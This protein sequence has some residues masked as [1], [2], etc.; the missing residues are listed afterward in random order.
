VKQELQD[1]AAEP[2]Q[3]PFGVPGAVKL[4]RALG[5]TVGGVC[6]VFLATLASVA[7]H[8][9]HPLL[10]RVVAQKVAA[11]VAKKFK[12]SVQLDGLQRFGLE[13]VE[14]RRLR[15]RD[16][17]GKTV[18]DL[19]GVSLHPPAWSAVVAG[20]QQR[21][22][23]L[24]ALRVSRAEIVLSK[25]RG[26]LTLSEALQRRKPSIPKAK[27]IAAAKRPLGLRIASLRVEALRVR[28]EGPDFAPKLDARLRKIALSLKHDGRATAVRLQGL[29]LE[30]DVALGGK[31]RAQ[32][33][34]TIDAEPSRSKWLVTTRAQGQFE[35]VG[36]AHE[37]S[38]D[39]KQIRASLA[40]PGVP[41]A[42]LKQW[43][44]DMPAKG[45]LGLEAR[46]SGR[47]PL[48]HLK[49]RL[50]PV[51]GNGHSAGEVAIDLAANV[52][53]INQLAIRLRSRAFDLSRMSVRAPPSRLDATVRSRLSWTKGGA[54]HLAGH[55]ESRNSSL[56]GRA[57]PRLAGRFEASRQRLVAWLHAAELGAEGSVWA[58]V[59]D[60]EKPA[61]K[62]RVDFAAALV[63]PALQRLSR[64]RAWIPALKSRRLRGKAALELSGSLR[65]AQLSAYG[66]ATLQRFAYAPAKASA[67]GFQ[68]TARL[69]GPLTAL[70]IQARGAAHAVRL[71]QRELDTL[72]FS[73]SG[74]LKR[75]RL[76]TQAEAEDGSSLWLA[77]WLDH[78]ARDV[79]D[80]RVKWSQGLD[81]VAGSVARIVPASRRVEDLNLR[82]FG[83]TLKG[84][85][86][87]DQGVPHGELIA[88]GISLRS[89]GRSWLGRPLMRGRFGARLVLPTTPDTRRPARLRIELE[90]VA[91]VHPQWA[92]ASGSVA[93]TFDGKRLVPTGNLNFGAGNCKEAMGNVVLAGQKIRLGGPLLRR[94]SWQRVAG[95]VVLRTQI[96]QPECLL[97]P[98]RKLMG[99]KVPQL[100]G[101]TAIQLRLSR[102]TNKG[103]PTLSLK[104]RTLRMRAHL[105]A[106]KPGA[107]SWRSEK[108]DLL[109]DASV[110][111]TGEL[112]VHA[113]VLPTQKRIAFEKLHAE[114][115]VAH[116]ELATQFEPKEVWQRPAALL[117]RLASGRQARRQPIHARLQLP[118]QG[119]EQ[120]SM[121]PSPLPKHFKDWA[122]RI[123]GTL[124]FDGSLARPSIAA[125]LRLLRIRS[126][127]ESQSAGGIDSDL[128]L[129]Y[130]D[131]HWYGHAQF[132]RRGKALARIEGRF[133][134]D[135]SSR[136]DGN[137]GP[138]GPGNVHL[139][140]S[141]ARV[142]T[143]PLLGNRGL[144]GRV[145][146]TLRLRQPPT[147]RPTL[148][149]TIEVKK[150]SIRG[151]PLARRVWLR[152]ESTKGK[153]RTHAEIGIDDL[154]GGR[155]L[156]Q[157][158]GALLRAKQA[159]LP[160]YDRALP[161]EVRV[162]AKRFSLAGFETLSGG[163][164][165]AAGGVLHGVAQ[166]NYQP[167]RAQPL[168]IEAK[169]TL[170]D[171]KVHGFGQ[172]L[173]GLRATLR[174]EGSVLRVEGLRAQANGGELDGSGR[175][176]FEGLRPTDFQAQLGIDEERA[177]PI[178]FGGR[179]FGQLSG[180]F[181]V[182]Y[183]IAKA[184]SVKPSV[185]RLRVVR[186]KLKLPPT[187]ARN[188][189]SLQ[190]HPDVQRAD[191]RS[192]SQ[193]PKP[194]RSNAR[195]VEVIVRDMAL[196]GA[197]ARLRFGTPATQP[198]VLTGGRARG[199]IEV[200][201]GRFRLLGKS[202][203]VER[204]R[205]DLSPG[206]DGV[207]T[208]G[209]VA[210][211]DAPDGSRV[212]AEYQGPVS[213][214]D[215]AKLKLRSAPERSQE[216]VASLLL[217]GDADDMQAS[218][219]RSSGEQRAGNLGAGLI[220][221]RLNQTLGRLAPR[222]SVGGTIEGA[223]SLRYQL[224]DRISAV[225]EIDSV[226]TSNEGQTSAEESPQTKLMLNW[227]LS[228]RWLV[229]GSLGFGGQAPSGV[230][231]FYQYRY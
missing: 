222:L 60:L 28:S 211:W 213:P 170:R 95:A 164:L 81:S 214:I 182:H 130:F 109:L 59:M 205:L 154:R 230:D 104:L 220:A 14:L 76:V 202:F 38:L 169:M 179:H 71:A 37:G 22:L 82:I 114:S 5:W 57:L 10:R 86:G 105:S 66:R 168:Q 229:R 172:R 61:T 197:G 48:L 183:A 215:P 89:L 106:Q 124:A 56:A 145:V 87:F 29:Q 193:A 226:E 142:A 143:L 185:L 107:N 45:R 25:H 83:G 174:N 103:W 138:L 84:R 4:L 137:L 115:A 42:K 74:P 156:L 225:A 26:Q 75:P 20:L 190:E 8:A 93:L 67:R 129:N 216:A 204:A 63:A 139:H 111:P 100:A 219:G 176:R 33:Q 126:S 201:E 173:A 49:G 228:P 231:L 18:A 65:G 195:R 198:L 78:E 7:L 191:H 55:L 116:V 131:G 165:Q 90:D 118:A 51:G 178:A 97:N 120:L 158:K 54:L 212:Y 79:Q 27:P 3:A 181:H 157:A 196:E 221:L 72:G 17:R 207:A 184:K 110:G 123:R 192:V 31:L 159:F 32:I 108:L 21:Q 44:P 94:A 133:N 15:L 62:R 180:Q 39:G 175:L 144:D 96:N 188:V 69:N 171:G 208:V 150:P 19:N 99:K 85:L 77:A 1:Q 119:V 64:L 186:A 135:L 46:L 160:S 189:Q 70:Q 132:R 203:V 91:Y 58:Q 167:R 194:A 140:F 35:G 30:D 149:G 218:S 155:L 101:T 223:R 136:L 41:A 47:L 43:L 23:K 206:A 102:E 53:Q 92:R 163:R 36:F 127:R 152:A 210:R 200:N 199:A 2:P 6:C 166:L 187:L 11:T 12:G 148:R 73:L 113:G 128:H 9:E 125:R 224:N 88:K 80:L 24:G 16:P 117:R 141:N 121:L 134:D 13:R 209:L 98:L 153:D 217:L 162:E 151:R 52:E 68:A 50:A 227:R 122:G 40:L 34:G 161:A 146:G 112:K 177:V 147:G